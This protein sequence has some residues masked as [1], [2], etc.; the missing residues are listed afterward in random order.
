MISYLDNER[1]N[2]PV[3]IFCHGNGYSAAMFNYYYERLNTDYRVL[4]LDFLNHGNSQS[5]LD[6]SG[7]H[8]YTDQLLAL[9][10][11]LGLSGVI[12]IGHSMGGAA[13]IQAGYRRPDLFHLSIGL[14]PIVLDLLGIML[15]WSFLNPLA[16]KARKRKRSFKS[17]Q[18]LEKIFE[19]HP[20]TRSWH[21]RDLADY[22]NSCFRPE[23]GHIVLSCTPEAEAK[24]FSTPEYRTL[25]YACR[26]SIPFHYVLADDSGIPSEKTTR[27]ISRKNKNAFFYRRGEQGIGDPVL[28]HHFPFEEPE[29][30]LDTIKNIIQGQNVPGT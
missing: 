1:K 10:T 22:L 21:R 16:R 29:W 26:L 17:R 28:T 18:A 8:F 25:R 23:G 30:T 4:G 7:W 3:L 6:F 20:L 12:G 11:H 24:N 5:R 19:K 15:R 27:K 13:L 14:D 9:M 2:K